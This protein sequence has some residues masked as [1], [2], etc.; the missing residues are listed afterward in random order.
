MKRKNF[1][2]LTIMAIAMILTI[3][4]ISCE[5]KKPCEKDNFGTVVVTN[6]TNT[7]IYVDVTYVGGD[8]YNDERKLNV[9]QSTEYQ[10]TPG[11]VE[12]WAT[13]AA[14]Y[15][16]NCN[17]YTDEYSL[18]QCETHDDPWVTIKKGISSELGKYDKYI[19]PT[20]KNK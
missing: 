12:E 2:S 13:P 20:T 5:P 8:E 4:L 15:A 9:G 10:M 7:T 19:K 17:W 3:G 6:N 14:D 18:A 16:C 1:L 11:R